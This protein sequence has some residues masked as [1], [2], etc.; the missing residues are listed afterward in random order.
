M[1]PA[2]SA[3]FAAI[4]PARTAED[5]REVRRLFEEYADGLGFDLGFQDF[6]RE[7][8]ELPGDYAEPAGCVLLARVEDES[9][10]CVGIRPLEGPICEMKRLYVRAG[11]RRGGP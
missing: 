4:A 11:R 1:A 7:L 2:A 6:Q 9:A 5:W 8:D 10:G 3:P